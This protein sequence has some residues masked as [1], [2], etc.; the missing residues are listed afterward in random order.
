MATSITY[1]EEMRKAKEAQKRGMITFVLIMLVVL[2]VPAMSLFDDAGSNAFK[3]TEEGLAIT[4]PD[5]T[6]VTVRYDEVTGVELSEGIAYGTCVK[7]GTEKQYRYGTWNNEQF[8]DY[9]LFTDMDFYSCIIFYTEQG[10]VVINFES[11]DTTAVLYESVHQVLT[12]GGYITA[13][14]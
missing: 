11:D 12:E 6:T 9:Q 2:L 10:V 13:G 5:N 3:W 4:Y 14:E 8:G 1:Q 7:G